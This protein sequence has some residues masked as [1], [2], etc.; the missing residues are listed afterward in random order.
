[1]LHY[2][3]VAPLALHFLNF[4]PFFFM[5]QNLMLHFLMLHYLTLH[6]LLLQYLLLRYANVALFYVALH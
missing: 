5:L 6:D 2:F 3:D 1:M 4:L